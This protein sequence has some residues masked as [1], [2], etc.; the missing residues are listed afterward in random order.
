MRR[1]RRKR[2]FSTRAAVDTKIQPGDG[3]GELWVRTSYGGGRTGTG[4]QAGAA[5]ASV[6]MT[7]AESVGEASGRAG[8]RGNQVRAR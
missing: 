2:R 1:W 6:G 7:D 4:Q 3:T 8:F 5:S